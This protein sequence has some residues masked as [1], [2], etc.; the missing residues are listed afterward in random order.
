MASP[1]VR[2]KHLCELQVDSLVFYR[3]HFIC[4]SYLCLLCVVFD[5]VTV[6]QRVY[7]ARYQV[8][9]DQSEPINQKYKLIKD[10][11]VVGN[12]TGANFIEL[13]SREFC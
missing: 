3:L 2:E 1:D 7:E 8:S 5:M 4:N 6:C 9:L 11:S 10:I 13:L 12:L